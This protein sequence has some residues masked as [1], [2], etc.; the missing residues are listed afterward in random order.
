MC[1]SKTGAWRTARACEEN[2]FKVQYATFCILRYLSLL[3]STWFLFTNLSGIKPESNSISSYNFDL[4]LLGTNTTILLL[5]PSSFSEFL[6]AVANVSTGMPSNQYSRPGDRSAFEVA[7]ICALRT[8]SD[9]VEA[10]FDE[11]WEEDE[12]YGKAP[13]DL[14]SY[15][16]GRIGQHNV[17]LAYMPGMGKGAAA[18]VAA[19]F[20]S[21]FPNIRLGL[22]VGIC[23]GVPQGDSHGDEILLGDVIISTGV[24]QFDF[25]RQFADGVVRKDTLQDNLG[26]PNLEIRGFLNKMQGLLART[27]LQKRISEYVA[28]V[29]SKDGFDGWRYPG[30]NEDKLY[31]ATYR[32]KHQDPAVCTVC[33]QCDGDGDAVCETALNSSCS[34]LQCDE[35]QLVARE[36]IHQALQSSLSAG[37]LAGTP[38]CT[39]HFGLTASGDIVM[40]SALHRDRIAAKEN[41]LGFEMEGA[42]VW[43][44]F[45]TVVI[46]GV[47]DYADSHKNKKWQRYAA[48]TAAACAKAFL[49]EWRGIDRASTPAQGSGEMNS[50]QQS[51]RGEELSDS[52]QAGQTNIFWGS[53]R[54]A[55]ICLLVAILTR[56]GVECP[57]DR[58][59]GPGLTLEGHLPFP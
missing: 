59:L 47:C 36:R 38:T 24:V 42:G 4:G 54:A 55:E 37:G 16:L 51:G 40:K 13:G 43:D 53:L 35:S 21:S 18:N 11:F 22:V 33:A 23:G 31:Q 12:Q 6:A 9:A 7:I 48:V 57:F 10:L 30:P 39:V 34:I 44:N 29:S 46:K 15:T 56:E 17:V 32:H 49:R 41:V 14:N 3:L 27:K 26:R 20:R 28:E 52:G 8:E 25:G 50:L 2:I 19:S 45:P 58:L 5:I 1:P